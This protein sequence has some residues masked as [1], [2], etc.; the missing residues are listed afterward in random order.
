MRNK[1][2]DMLAVNRIERKAKRKLTEL[3]IETLRNGEPIFV[4]SPRTWLYR[5]LKCDMFSL[6]GD[7]LEPWQFMT[8]SSDIK[9]ESYSDVIKGEE[10]LHFV[11]WCSNELLKLKSEA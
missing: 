10:E 4:K 5:E 11:E 3:E 6:P 1:V 7:I 2:L 8:N 9:Y